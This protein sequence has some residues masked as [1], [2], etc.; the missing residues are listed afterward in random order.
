MQQSS[1]AAVE[2]MFEAGASGCTDV[3]GFGLIGHLDE[4]AR[5]SQVASAYPYSVRGNIHH[6]ACWCLL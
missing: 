3:T 5:A 2:R 6:G 1:A 4:M